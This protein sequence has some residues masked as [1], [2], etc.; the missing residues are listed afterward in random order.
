MAESYHRGQTL[1]ERPGSAVI[2]CGDLEV[3]GDRGTGLQRGDCSRV[4]HL[5]CGPPCSRLSCLHQSFLKV[6]T[7]LRSLESLPSPPGHT[8]LQLPGAVLS[9]ICRE[10]PREGLGSTR[11][12]KPALEPQSSRPLG[13]THTELL[14]K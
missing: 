4:P 12:E 8:A 2:S 13:N 11:R 1:T 3:A 7:L 14:G 9:V 5:V 10:A 6:E